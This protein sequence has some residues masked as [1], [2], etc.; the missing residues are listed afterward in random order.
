VL[1]VPHGRHTSDLRLHPAGASQGVLSS[2]DARIEV[3]VAVYAWSYARAVIIL[4]QLDEI[5]NDTDIV[6][7]EIPSNK[8][9]GLFLLL[10]SAEMTID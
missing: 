4:I 6:R 10:E 2:G 5:I 7:V 3:A 1:V 8:D 9:C